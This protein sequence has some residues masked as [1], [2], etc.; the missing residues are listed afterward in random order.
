MIQRQRQP[1]PP[2][3][4]GLLGT[5]LLSEQRKLLLRRRQRLRGH[6]HSAEAHATL[7]AASEQRM[8]RWKQVNLPIGTGAHGLTPRH[9]N[10]VAI[11][12]GQGQSVADTL[13]A[14]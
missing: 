6:G 12:H 2:S 4:R 8:Q 7:D 14:T 9:F 5:W 11:A 1:A 3:L 10:L 13:P